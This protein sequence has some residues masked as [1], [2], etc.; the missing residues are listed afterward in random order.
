VRNRA[1]VLVAALAAAL[2]GLLVAFGAATPA[3][4]GSGSSQAV[5]FPV[6]NLLSYANSDFEGSANFI[7]VTNVGTISDSA[8]AAEHGNDSLKF[9]SASAGSTVLKLQEGSSATQIDVTGSDTYTLGGWFKLPAANSGESVTFGLGLYNSSGTWIGW[10]DTSALA[11]S[12]VTTWQYVQ[13]QITVPSAAAWALD[14]PEITLSNAAASQVTYMDMLVFEPYRAAQAIGA[15]GE[16]GDPCNYAYTNW[17]GTNTSIGPLQ[18]DK[19]FFD[20]SNTTG[21]TGDLPSTFVGTVCQKIEAYLGSSPWPVCILAY[22]GNQM[23]QTD[24]NDFLSTVPAAQ[25]L[26]IVWH[27]E[28]EGGTFSDEPGCPTGD[29]NAQSFVCEFQLQASMIDSSPDWGPNIFV[30]MDSSGYQYNPSG[31]GI[32]CN[33]IP[34]NNDQ[35]GGGADIYLV[36]FYQNNVV[37]G[38]NVNQSTG[39]TNWQNWLTCATAKDRPIGFGEYGLDQTAGTGTTCTPPNTSSQYNAQ[40]TAD[41]MTA[42]ASYLEALPMSG[43]TQMQNN[44]PFAMWDYW[45]SNYGGTPDNTVFNNTYGAI[46]AWQSIETAN[47]GG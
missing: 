17:T 31:T 34:P 24:M 16:C 21:G 1:L 46:T 33:Y 41:A 29:N 7:A 26:D 30:A 6:G 22:T 38:T 19:E 13:G 4:A 45:Y 5:P 44:V 10:S 37:A 32:G 42:D 23:T 39:A 35:T 28:A 8:A 2:S 3:F 47:G 18:S 14:S 12:A 36:D 11:L 25:E 40:C 20:A 43:Q 9:T 15:H 27:S